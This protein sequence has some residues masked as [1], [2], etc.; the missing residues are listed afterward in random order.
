M[1]DIIHSIR[2]E[3]IKKGLRYSLNKFW[4]VLLF[5]TFS[6]NI[7]RATRI[8]KK[9]SQHSPPLEYKFRMFPS[10]NYVTTRTCRENG[11][12]LAI[13]PAFSN[14][15]VKARPELK[16]AT[17]LKKFD[18]MSCSRNRERKCTSTSVHDNTAKINTEDKN[19]QNVGCPSGAY[20]AAI[21]LGA[22]APACKLERK[23]NAVNYI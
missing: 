9:I 17:R 1:P 16:R 4:H 7:L 3:N 13:R 20:H 15:F 8:D 11:P 12:M 6:T 19:P 10:P 23:N 2:N 5:F 18:G 22:S 14:S 21:I